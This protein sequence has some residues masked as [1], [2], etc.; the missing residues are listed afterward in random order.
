[1]RNA[2][3]LI[4]YVDRLGCKNVQDLQVLLDTEL[5][6]LFAGV[7]ILPFYY[8]IDGE[9]AGFDPIDHSIVDPRLGDWSDVRSLSQSV[10]IMA[11]LI[12]NHVSAQS[13]QFTDFQ[14]KGEQ[15]EFASMFLTYDKVFPQ[16]ATEQELIRIYRPRPGFSFTPMAIGGSAKKLIWTTFTSNQV[17]ID[18]SSVPGKAYLEHILDTFAKAGIT[19][20]RLDA[21]GYAIKKRGTSCFM[22]EDTF[23]FIALLAEKA[24][25]KGMEVLVEIHSYYQT[26]IEI[27]QKVGYVYDFALPVLVLD[28]LFNG[29]ARNLKKW[30]RISP[31]NAFTVL[32]THDGIGVIDVASEDGKPGLIEDEVLERIVDQI[33]EN[34]EGRSLKATGAAASNLDLYQVNC[35]YFEALGSDQL[36]YLMARAIQFFVPGIP[37]VYYVGL[38]G[39]D[40]D[41]DLLEQTNVGRDINRH[42]Y[43]REEIR[44][45]LRTPMIQ[46]LQELM[47]LRNNH[48][49]FQGDFHLV[50]SMDST[51]IIRWTNEAMEA[52]LS[53]DLKKR[54]IQITFSEFEGNTSIAFDTFRV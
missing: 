21:V 36:S 19:M 26:Q 20:I 25:R 2:I 33:H 31:R 5:K 45:K 27:A 53:L 22:I 38:F 30:L 35:T 8:P 11:D 24:N 43:S 49:A 28:T 14:T 13:A 15:S 46:K 9:D 34:S 32:D 47:I 39:D 23:D 3:Q 50:D 48:P 17:D 10:E 37:Q 44:E 41:M 6:G 51:L 4:T 16:G 7:H 42:Y 18:V 40:N 54:G 52:Q 1:M 29:N 12:V